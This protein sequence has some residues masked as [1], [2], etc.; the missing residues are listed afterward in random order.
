M[1][2]RAK[3]AVGRHI[4]PVRFLLFAAVFA[5]VA[6][7]LAA[8]GDGSRTA[9]LMGFDA[10]A[11]VFLA[12][13]LTLLRS[14]AEQMRGRAVDNDANR[15]GLLAIS[16]L[17]SLVVL[18]AVGTLIASPEKL[19]RGDIVLIVATL[20]LAWLFANMVFM[21]HYAHLYYLQEGGRDR[22][23]LE[24]PGV[25]EPGYWDFLYFSFTLGM[26]FQTSD[27]TISG[28]HM[29]RVAL[30]HCMAAFVFNMGI[31]AFTV[32]ALGGP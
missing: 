20:L 19:D 6:G 30:G 1:S 3:L 29:R 10:G 28:A 12:A 32:N 11:L 21:L 13:S 31:L 2:R 22:G 23:G 18:F 4:A 15:A 25:K 7:A 26:T 14:D 5:G 9:L 8:L 16:V 27:V 24:V 17:L